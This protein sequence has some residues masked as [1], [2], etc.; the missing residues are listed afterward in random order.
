MRLAG[1]F[2]Y[3]SN[4]E[5]DGRAQCS[6]PTA[7]PVRDGN[8]CRCSVG[9]ESEDDRLAGRGRGDGHEC[10]ACDHQAQPGDL[11]K[12]VL[13]GTMHRRSS[14]TLEVLF[15]ISVLWLFV[16]AISTATDIGQKHQHSWISSDIVGLIL[17]A[18]IVLFLHAWAEASDQSAP[19][20]APEAFRGSRPAAAAGNS[21]PTVTA[22]H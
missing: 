8:R 5:C 12:A 19:T 2:L 10:A 7:C 9:V 15:W 3:V 4:R 21:A 17:S 1:Y 16:V 18:I 14:K 6:S 13:A 22:S 20:H 11:A